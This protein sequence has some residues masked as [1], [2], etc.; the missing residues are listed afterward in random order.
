MLYDS[1][2]LEEGMKKNLDINLNGKFIYVKEV[3]KIILNFYILFDRMA[4]YI[5]LRSNK[6]AYTM[7]NWLGIY[8]NF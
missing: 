6:K 8:D 7:L 3:E 4:I 5:N 1:F 2:K